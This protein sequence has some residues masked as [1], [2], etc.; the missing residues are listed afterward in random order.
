MEENLENKES[1]DDGD[2]STSSQARLLPVVSEDAGF[3]SYMEQIRK[4]PSLSAEE[5]YMLAKTYLEHHDMEAA[6]KLV[7][8]HLKLVAKIAM[9]YR[10]YGLPISELVSEGNLGLMQAVKK[11]DPEKGFRLT[12]YAIWWIKAFMQEYIL[13]SWSIVKIGTTAAQK[14]L[15][16]NLSKVKRKLQSDDAYVDKDHYAAIAGELGVTRA[17]VAEMDSRMSRDAYME[18]PI[19][20]EEGA[21]TLLDTLPSTTESYE[22]EFADT[23]EHMQKRKIMQ[24]ALEQLNEREREILL[25]R[26]MQEQ[27]ATLEELSQ[28]YD[29]SRERVR[30]VENRAFEKIQEYMLGAYKDRE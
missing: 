29:I 27:P 8:S 13:K 20:N 10:G 4:I 1:H 25:S 26:R 9:T 5:E 22:T 3:Q 16:F 6:H 18:D 30:Q 7:M 28:K 21:Q 23:Q 14:K 19:G 12:T 17:E 15:F 11:F 24:Q 2:K